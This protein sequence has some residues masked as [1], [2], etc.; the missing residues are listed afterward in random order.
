MKIQYTNVDWLTATTKDDKVGLYWYETFLSL[1][2]EVDGLT[3]LENRWHNGFYGGLGIDGLKW[4]F[5]EAL[6]YIIIGSS[7]MAGRLWD[8]LNPK[9]KK[10]TRLDLCCDVLMPEPYDMAGVNYKEIKE[11]ETDKRRKY[12]LFENTHGGKTL[13]VGSRHSQAYGRLYDKGNESGQEENQKLWRFE[14]EIKK[15]LSSVVAERLAKVSGQDRQKFIANYIGNWFADRMVTDAEYII[16]GE[17]KPLVVQVRQT[18]VDR[19]LGWLR[20]Q[21]AP[22]VG[23]L[24]DN[25]LGRQVARSLFTS[26]EQLEQLGEVYD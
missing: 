1:G 11:F 13:Y 15:P 6:G 17:F 5:S 22:T 8:R 24:I 12:T 25:G 16:N 26:R 20:T 19:K 23:M 10:V 9:P 18:T 21:V 2:K 14:V 4:G 3:M 7:E